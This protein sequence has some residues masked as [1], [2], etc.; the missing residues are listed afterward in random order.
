MHTLYLVW[1]KSTFNREIIRRRPWLSIEIKLRNEY[2]SSL[3]AEHVTRSVI[4]IN[5][6]SFVH[7]SIRPLLTSRVKDLFFYFFTRKIKRRSFFC[8]VRYRWID[9]RASGRR[10][11]SEGRNQFV[12]CCWPPPAPP[13]T[14]KLCLLDDFRSV[15]KNK[16]PSCPSKQ[17]KLKKNIFSSATCFISGCMS[18]ID[19]FS[20]SLSQIS[21]LSTILSRLR[22]IT[23]IALIT[24]IIIIINN[25]SVGHR[26]S[27][28]PYHP[29]NTKK[30]FS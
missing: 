30:K 4:I 8:L 21:C 24:L 3:S 23:N 7:P 28:Q 17:V 1:K 11:M 2:L 29:L 26:Q 12:G 25:R 15:L 20:Y 19:L 14:N 27:H 13:T 16:S 18:G 9:G 10:W 6:S 22:S 5:G